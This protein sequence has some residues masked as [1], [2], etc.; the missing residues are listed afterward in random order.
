M[1]VIAELPPGVLAP[2]QANRPIVALASAAFSQ[3]RMK[4]GLAIFVFIVGIAIVGPAFAP[5]SPT[6]FVASPFAHPSG[7]LLLGADVLGRDVFSRFLNGGRVIL[8]LSLL[9]TMLGV[10]LGLVIGLV[11]A[12]WGG[13]VDEVLMRAMDVLLA[14]PQL[15]LALVIVATV[16]SSFALQVV[17]VGLTTAPR[18]ARVMRAAALEIVHRDFV[19]S[20]EALGVS[21]MR[22]VR[23]EILPNVTS[24]LLVE[25]SLR[26]TY[27]IGLIASLS[28]LGFG[29][30]P[31]AANWAVMIN[32]NRNGLVIQPWSV[33]VPVIAIALLTIGTSLMSDAV[34]RASIGIAR[35]GDGAQ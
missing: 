35:R 34:A 26:F 19:Q 10:G 27:S 8:I 15:V 9:A 4:V 33:V 31:P 32:E 13:I 3:T 30:N 25:L 17:A 18:V 21:R 5:Y 29:Q 28:F 22:I 11:A 23:G 7:S 6:A 1:S 24:P 14:F 12:Y 2:T 20:A 16:G